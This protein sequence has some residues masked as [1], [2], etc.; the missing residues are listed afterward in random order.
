M[1][2]AGSTEQATRT[3]LEC[4]CK[5]DARYLSVP[6]QP[7]FSFAFGFGGLRS[8]CWK[9]SHSSALR[10]MISCDTLSLMRRQGMDPSGGPALLARYID[11]DTAKLAEVINALALKK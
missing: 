10:V 9:R 7:C 4:G 1:T 8:I 3:R 2:S 5:C 6:S 11:T